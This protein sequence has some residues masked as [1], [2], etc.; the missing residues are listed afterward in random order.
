MNEE[1]PDEAMD[2]YIKKVCSDES[3]TKEQAFQLEV[4]LR[5]HQRMGAPGVQPPAAVDLD[6]EVILR[7]LQIAYA[8]TEKEILDQEMH[9]KPDDLFQTTLLMGMAIGV[10]L[11]RERRGK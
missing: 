7:Y 5:I 2:E 6:E 8:S 10:H 1:R 3:L 4:L 11:E 9:F